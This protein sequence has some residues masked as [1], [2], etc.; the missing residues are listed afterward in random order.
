M[1]Q[2]AEQNETR[3]S[4]AMLPDVSQV[5]DDIQSSSGD[6]G[7]TVA[8]A[9]AD[10]PD[11]LNQTVVA[12]MLENPDEDTAKVLASDSAVSGPGDDLNAAPLSPV[13]LA[14]DEN[15][16]PDGFHFSIEPDAFWFGGEGTEHLDQSLSADGEIS[17]DDRSGL[18]V[19]NASAHWGSGGELAYTTKL[20]SL[21]H[22]N[23]AGDGVGGFDKAASDGVELS[24]QP[25]TDVVL[26]PPAA[27][28]GDF[29]L[30][31]PNPTPVSA[32][33]SEW[34][35]PNWI[36]QSSGTGGGSGSF[37]GI[38]TTN[39]VVNQASSGLVINVIYDASVA[40]A[41]TGFTADVQSVVNY[42]ESHFSNPIT[43]TIDV[44][45]GEV[46][47]YSLGSGALGE[48]M[49]YFDQVSYSQ[50]QNALVTNLNA[51]GDTA[52]AASLPATSP[53]IGRWW[54]STAE[55]EALGLTS[56]SNNPDGYVGFNS[57]S[58]IF[59]YNDSNGVPSGQYDFTPVVAHEISEVMGRQMF[60]GTNAF[61]TGASYDP[62]DLFHYSAPGVRAFT[63]Y[64]GYASADG[65]KTSL[66]GF[67][68]IRGGDFGDWASS[69]GNDAF[70]AFAKP[71]V[72]NSVT[73]SDLTE[74]N[75][76]GWKP[77]SSASPPPTAPVVTISLAQDTG[78]SA[79]DKI[80]SNDALTGTADPNA[81]VKITAGSSVLGSAT[82]NPSGVWSFAPVGLA[83]GSY[84]LTASETNAAGLTGSAALSFTLD[85]TAPVVTS[86]IVS[87]SGI[88]GGAG[89]LTAGQLAVFTL[90]LTE[91]VVISGAPALALNDSGIAVYD[92]AHST[93]TSLVFDYTVAAGQVTSALAV[94]AVNLSG[95]SVTDIAGNTANLTGA[96]I[97]FPA[98]SVNATTP[99]DT[100][101]P[102][103]VQAHAH[104]ILSSSVS[105][106]AS[107]GVLVGDSDAN[108]SDVL[109]VS[110]VLG[111]AGNVGQPVAGAFGQLTLNAD[112]SYTYNNTNPSAV[113]A[114]GGVTEDQFNYTVSNGHGGT[115]DATLSVLITS[116]NDTYL[117]GSAGGTLQGGAGNYVLDG[118]AGNMNLTA[119]TQGQQWLVGGPGDLLNAGPSADTFMFS[120][121][122]GKETINN[123]N[124]NQDVIDLPQSS[125]PSVTA[126][127]ADVQP[128]GTDTLIVV[129]ANDVI[130]LSHVAA[131]SLHAQNFHFLV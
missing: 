2:V 62:L 110:A 123:F 77:A 49:T 99:V 9:K 39:S 95:A 74:L 100:T 68:T 101:T 20:A 88:S 127:H 34:P 42:F 6:M 104:D 67:N 16:A 22:D 86:D 4:A 33:E 61:G 30:S 45:Y 75:L 44:G 59:A 15:T 24:H 107:N 90:A 60:D 98:L 70:N 122:F 128:S 83:D 17:A 131:T 50:L 19:E 37:G 36:I 29:L 53:V 51:I 41:P 94:T 114:A 105:A 113:T 102:N 91:P 46:D 11:G 56:A 1:S 72:V 69:A 52:A 58:N 31:A 117:T 125:F 65:G 97:S 35:I 109:S 87:G 115:A 129:D 27:T 40:N 118:S 66:D 26:L 32:P 28:D 48:S 124:P 57:A 126:L 10:L 103:V 23:G 55:A 92:P 54:V 63:G 82:A 84:T 5:I 120:P 8:P 89:I 81:V 47:G 121:G 13:L 64:T 38:T 80:T 25:A 112:G 21:F 130:T 111:S 85:T 108:P 71:G 93:S 14:A 119:G 116:P 3:A 12:V 79:T 7:L 78:V 43:I 76:L 18:S 96:D 73:Q 106:S